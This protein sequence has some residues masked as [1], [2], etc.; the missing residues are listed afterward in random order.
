MHLGFE[1][2]VRSRDEN[3]SRELGFQSTVV[4]FDHGYGTMSPDR[5]IARF[6]VMRL[7]PFPIRFAVELHAAV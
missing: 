1:I 3:P 7:A 5:T 4:A 6:N 2:F